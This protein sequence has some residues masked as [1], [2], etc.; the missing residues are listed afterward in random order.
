M[1]VIAL[2]R[3]NGRVRRKPLTVIFVTDTCVTR[4]IF[5]SFRLIDKRYSKCQY[6]EAHIMHLFVYLYGKIGQEFN[7]GCLL[8]TS[9]FDPLTPSY[10]RNEIRWNFQ[11]N[12]KQPATEINWKILGD[13][14]PVKC[15]SRNKIFQEYPWTQIFRQNDKKCF[16]HWNKLWRP[17]IFIPVIAACNGCDIFQL[18]ASVISSSLWII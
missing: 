17:K 1:T 6:E 4:S 14:T 16:I 2:V 13:P 15:F 18:C 7:F 11:F 12:W 10:C 5:T 9:T 8:I 3:C